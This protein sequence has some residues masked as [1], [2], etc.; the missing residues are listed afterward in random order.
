MKVG[1]AFAPANISCIF[2]AIIGKDAEH[3]GSIG[4]GFTLNEGVTAEVSFSEKSEIFFNNKKINLPT[5]ADVVNRLVQIHAFGI[6]VVLTT[7]LPLGCGFGIS[8]AAALATAYALNNLFDL[9]RKPI[10][11]ARIAHVAEVENGTGLGDVANQYMGGCLLKTKPSYLFKAQRIL[12]DGTPVYCKVFSSVET[13]SI[14]SDASAQKY[15]AEAADEAI[16]E[17]ELSIK[18]Y[19]LRK[20]TLFSDIIKISRQFAVQ[21]RLLKNKEVKETI[22]E[23][24][25]KG[26]FAS[27]IMLGNAVFSSIPFKGA[28]RYSI[29]PKGAAGSGGKR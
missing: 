9:K 19:E 14:I 24:E 26:G 2:K 16:R 4:L 7:S 17:I 10:D 1:R 22:S 15:I 28:T 12:L 23:I 5:V 6:R 11:L 27:M 25:K 20:K 21:S 8:G 18:N 29:S 13:Q 3:T